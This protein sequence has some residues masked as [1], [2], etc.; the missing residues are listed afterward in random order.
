MN[1]FYCEKLKMFSEIHASSTVFIHSFQYNF[2]TKK[3]Y[4]NPFTVYCRIEYMY[5]FHIFNQIP[6][7]QQ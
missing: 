3:M 5:F 6:L 1:D 2:S 7:T 4:K